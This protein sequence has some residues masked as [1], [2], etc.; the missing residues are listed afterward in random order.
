MSD[1]RDNPSE[2]RPQDG[3]LI[4]VT[5]QIISH[6]APDQFAK[7]LAEGREGFFPSSHPQAITMFAKL[8]A[9][10]AGVIEKEGHDFYDF[11]HAINFQALA[12]CLSNY[13]DPHVQPSLEDPIRP[14][15]QVKRIFYRQVKEELNKHQ[16]ACIT[17]GIRRCYYDIR[18]DSFH[19]R[20]TKRRRLSALSLI[21]NKAQLESL[22]LSTAGHLSSGQASNDDIFFAFASCAE[23]LKFI[24]ESDPAA[25]QGFEREI[26]FTY[27]NLV[28]YAAF[29]VFLEVAAEVAH[30]ALWYEK[31]LL[32]RLVA[33]FRESFGCN[34]LQDDTLL[35][36]MEAFSLSPEQSAKYFLPV[37]FFNFNGRYLRYPTYWKIMSPAMGLL[38]IVI[39]KHDA[40]WSRTVGGNLARAADVVAR[41]L[42]QFSNV[43]V[44]VRRK[45]K[46]RGDIDLAVYDVNSRHV[47]VCEIK[48]VYDKHRTVRQMQRFEESKV[49]LNH[50]ITQLRLAIAALSSN[51]VDMQEVFGRPLPPPIQVHGA[52]LTWIDPIDLTVGTEDED[53]LSLNFATFR[54]LFHRSGGDLAGMVHAVS[55]LRNIWCVAKRRPVDLEIPIRTDLEVQFALIDALSDISRLSLSNVVCEELRLLP[56]LPDNWGQDRDQS[57]E[58]VSYLGDTVKSLHRD[59]TVDLK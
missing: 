11:S 52:L 1:P 17:H 43:V 22:D 20:L 59:S 19:M 33:I 23:H 28:A 6:Y 16:A 39:R 36:L 2:H 58:F 26:G 3:E 30:H 56:R 44:A 4:D 29:I 37:P 32:L 40:A 49:N 34:E 10:H 14:D 7:M 27:A 18:Q 45:I 48:T 31:S 12:N 41:I 50:A 24:R 15:E 35:Y 46:R 9:Y 55:E 5:D 57:T 21:D 38:T 54:Y 8:A 42:P 13:V 25:W 53:L 51:E 47:I